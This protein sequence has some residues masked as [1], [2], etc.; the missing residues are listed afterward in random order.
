M[1][2]SE[3]MIGRKLATSPGKRRGRRF[4][5]IESSRCAAALYPPPVWTA[6]GPTG[7][8]PVGSTLRMRVRPATRGAP[9]LPGTNR[10]HPRLGVVTL[11]AG[12][13][14]D[15]LFDRQPRRLSGA[16]GQ[17]GCS[18]CPR[19]DSSLRTCPRRAWSQSTLAAVGCTNSAI[20]TVAVTLPR[21]LRKSWSVQS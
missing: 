13:Q 2:D 20:G 17:V 8:S 4:G 21:D 12:G 6:G 7:L 16:V 10:A 9:V 11:L 15:A 14:G 18:E 5:S 1:I 3:S 19:Q